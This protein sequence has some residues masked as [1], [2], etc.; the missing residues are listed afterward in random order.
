MPPLD[1]SGGGVIAYVSDLAGA[2]GIQVMNADGTDQRRLTDDYHTSPSWSPDGRQIVFKDGGAHKWTISMVDALSGEITNVTDL[3]S[4]GGIG[5]PDWSPDGNSFALINDYELYTMNTSGSAVKSLIHFPGNVGTFGPDWSAD[6]QQLVFAVDFAD[7]ADNFDIYLSDADGS[8]MVQL[9][10]HEEHD[11]EPAWS[12]D[13]TTIAFE[14]YRDGNWEL[15][16]MNAD[17]SNI[18]NISNSPDREHH[19]AWSPD[20]DQNRLPQ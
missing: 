9:T 5:S 1:A 14:S 18:Q 7:T 19:P 2:P 20:G 8:N 17:G 6:G 15:F 16:T 13:G 3:N 11:R 10:S 12:P 4:L